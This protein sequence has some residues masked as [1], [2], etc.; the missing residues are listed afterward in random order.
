MKKT[1]FFIMILVCFCIAQDKRNPTHFFENKWYYCLE[2]HIKPVVEKKM[3]KCS[4]P[5]GECAD[6]D[7]KGNMIHYKDSEGCEFWYE[8][9]TKGNNIHEMN[10]KGAEMWYEYDADGNEI[11][12][13]TI[14]V[15]L[16]FDFELWFK[17]FFDEKKNIKY[18]C[19]VDDNGNP[20]F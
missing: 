2:S 16:G 17:W 3:P 19:V 6:Y 5:I 13:R 12:V 14:L 9:D 7:S 15:R 4:T 8:Y 10:S 20:V 18:K 11:Y 1:I